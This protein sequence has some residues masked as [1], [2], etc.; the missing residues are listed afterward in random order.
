MVKV[1]VLLFRLV[2]FDSEKKVHILP[3][4]FSLR[5][6]TG[7]H[8]FSV[9]ELMK[10]N[11]LL[12]SLL[13]ML[14]FQLI[15]AQD[16]ITKRLSF[17]KNGYKCE[18]VFEH[19]LSYNVEPYFK[20]RLVSIKVLDLRTNSSDAFIILRNN[21]IT[22]PYTVED[23]SAEI[24][25]RGLIFPI[26]GYVKTSEKFR[27]TLAGKSTSLPEFPPFSKEDL[28]WLKTRDGKGSIVGEGLSGGEDFWINRGK[29][30]H[31]NVVDIYL[32]GL[33]SRITALLEKAAADKEKTAATAK[34]EKN[35]KIDNSSTNITEEKSDNSSARSTSSQKNNLKETSESKIGI[36]WFEM[37]EKNPEAALAMKQ[38]EIRQRD[39]MKVREEKQELATLRQYYH[40]PT[41][42]YDPVSNRI[43]HLQ[44]N[45]TQRTLQTMQADFEESA[46]R[47]NEERRR[48][49]ERMQREDEERWRKR[50]EAKRRANA[51]RE[52]ARLRELEIEEAAVKR[53]V[54]KQIAFR[55]LDNSPIDEKKI[56]RSVRLKRSDMRE[57][58]AAKSR[59]A[60][61]VKNWQQEEIRRK[62][63]SAKSRKASIAAIARKIPDTAF[64][65]GLAAFR[66][67]GKWGF[68]DKGGKEVVQAT[69]EQLWGQYMKDGTAKVLKDGKYGV[70]NTKGKFIIP[71][72]YKKIERV[73]SSL[74]AVSN[75]EMY[76]LTDL[77]NKPV[78]TETFEA[79]QGT[80]DGMFI[81]RK[82]GKTGMQDSKFQPLTPYIYDEI[83]S[84]LMQGRRAA[85]KDGMW[86]FIDAQ[87]K[88]V[89]PFKYSDADS[90]GSKIGLAPVQDKTTGKWGY[91]N[92]E[93]KTVIPFNYKDATS[94]WEGWY[95]SVQMP[96]EY[97]G[98]LAIDGRGK[99][100]VNRENTYATW[101]S[102][103]GI[104]QI[105]N[106]YYYA[107]SG[108][109]VIKRENIYAE[110]P[111]NFGQAVVRYDVSMN[112]Y[113]MINTAGEI[114]V[115][116][117][118]TSLYPFEDEMWQAYFEG[119]KQT[120]FINRKGEIIF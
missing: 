67:L 100:L 114:V 106:N 70:V 42:P 93:G 115:P 118:F 65:N 88:E 49:L 117:V 32:G 27:F 79:I 24:E 86:G 90:Y 33:E 38:E 108:E 10:L 113:G 18:V 28:A 26:T 25:A 3:A 31:F 41:N 55:K 21:G 57:I 62:S 46:R 85:K 47:K 66:Y 6:T 87:G 43:R 22:F 104:I 120:F 14:S 68:V 107:A 110:T 51:A 78:L 53:E 71:L 116:P 99:I 94:F 64:R 36:T 23:A 105:D 5:E 30:D 17:N 102:R 52:A 72:A 112:S 89:I 76:T 12:F 59:F 81:M 16:K 75:G 50:E 20:T 9:H 1:S 19:A 83:S 48:N 103:E 91:I 95:A 82:D 37:Y 15:F 119:Y 92:P 2:G 73:N 29:I 8:F 13:C 58:A 109:P 111:F 74:Y 96:S 40:N 11:T 98:Y 84:Y 44:N 39:A 63:E 101:V 35:K 54:Q 77:R 97:G 80:T 45:E 61:A 69:Y 60:I 56:E 34:T 7:I 4:N